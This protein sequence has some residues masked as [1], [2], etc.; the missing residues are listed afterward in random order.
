MQ[1]FTGSPVALKISLSIPCW[2]TFQM[3][4]SLDGFSLP[5][6]ELEALGSGH[7]QECECSRGV[8]AKKEDAELE[9][10]RINEVLKVGIILTET[11]SLFWFYKRKINR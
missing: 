11:R 9:K 3:K 4:I 6:A 2:S 1:A 10:L 5:S 8:R 7:H